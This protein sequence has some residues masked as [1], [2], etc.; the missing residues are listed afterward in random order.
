MELRSSVLCLEQPVPMPCLQPDESIPTRIRPISLRLIATVYSHLQNRR[1][2][3][4]FRYISII[5]K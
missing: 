1:F 2:L 5:K 4:P 3:Q